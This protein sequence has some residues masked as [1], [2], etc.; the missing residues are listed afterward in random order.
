MWVDYETGTIINGPVYAIP[1]NF[2]TEGL[3]DSEIS[4]K[5]RAEGHLVLGFEPS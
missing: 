2:E 4:E 1:I 3:S 5:A